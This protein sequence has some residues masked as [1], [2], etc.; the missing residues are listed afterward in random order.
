MVRLHNDVHHER[1]KIFQCKNGVSARAPSVRPTVH[2][3]SRRSVLMPGRRAEPSS[4]LSFSRSAPPRQF[5]VHSSTLSAWLVLFS[6]AGNQ[7]TLARNTLTYSNT[8]HRAIAWRELGTTAPICPPFWAGIEDQ[9]C[10]ASAVLLKSTPSQKH[11]VTDSNNGDG[12]DDERRAW[13][14]PPAG[15]GIGRGG[16]GSG[17][18]AAAARDSFGGFVYCTSQ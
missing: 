15:R 9:L 18:G 10:C 7:A 13:S 12:D 8:T 11:R 4:S 16:G 5:Q 1:T 3:G 6:A 17:R 14:L 2:P